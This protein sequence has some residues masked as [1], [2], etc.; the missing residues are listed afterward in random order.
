M[1]YSHGVHHLIQLIFNNGHNYIKSYFYLEIDSEIFINN[2][3][4]SLITFKIIL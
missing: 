3:K 1:G 2:M 4:I